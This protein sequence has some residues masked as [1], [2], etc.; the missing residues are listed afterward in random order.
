MPSPA[1][2]LS[3]PERVEASARRLVEAAAELITE[4]GWEAMTAAEIGRRAGYSRTMVHARYGS[5]GA[6]LDT[7]FRTT[8]EARLDTTPAHDANGLAQ[9][10]GH[11]G[12]IIELYVEDPAFTRA[13]F[14]LTF[15][16]V[17]STSPIRGRIQDW[18][19]DGAKT[20]ETGLRTGIDDGSVR[21]DVDV[22][23][24]T[25]DISTAGLG[26]SY[27]WIVF[28]DT[29]P[30]DRELKTVRSRIIRDYGVQPAVRRSTASTPG[31]AAEQDPDPPAS[32][33]RRPSSPGPRRR[34]AA[35]PR[36]AR[37]PD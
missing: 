25:T 20:V 35:S 33:G 3:Q 21:R 18:L 2:G 24:A 27:Q 5:K 6:L 17:K 29:Y 8:Y 9:A 11:F 16:A 23:A 1:R 28:G 14:V 31:A 4:K 26:V 22:A 37:P 7:L 13:V 36:R 10:L 32:V 30:L 34:S 19:A 12:R 15:E